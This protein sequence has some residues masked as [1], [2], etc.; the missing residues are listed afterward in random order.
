MPGAAQ[1]IRPLLVGHDVDEI[2]AFG[3][4]GGFPESVLGID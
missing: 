3:H 1:P 4:G 2:R